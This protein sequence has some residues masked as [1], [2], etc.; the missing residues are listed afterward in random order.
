MSVRTLLMTICEM[1]NDRRQIKGTGSP[2]RCQ[3]VE[4]INS[5]SKLLKCIIGPFQTLKLDFNFLM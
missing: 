2:V 3:L 4:E 1:N 5:I